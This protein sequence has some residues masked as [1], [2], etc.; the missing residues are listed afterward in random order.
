MVMLA[1]NN[2]FACGLVEK[3]PG[4][5]CNDMEAVD[6]QIEA[7]RAM[8][9]Y[10]DAKQGGPGQGWYR[11]VTSPQ[12]ARDVIYAGKL[13]VVLGIEVDSLFNCKLG[14]NCSIAS[15]RRE[16]KR[17]Y[18]LG[19]RHFFP[20]HLNSNDYG[21][22]AL[23]NVLTT[24]APV[25]LA[26]AAVRDCAT[27]GY[28]FHHPRYVFSPDGKLLNATC[29]AQGLTELGKSLIR[30]MIRAKVFIDVNHMSALAFNDTLTI[31]EDYNYP[32]VAGH[33]GFLD[34]SR[35]DSRH[36]GNLK[37]DQLERIRRLG[38]MVG[39]ILH[40]GEL[41][42]IATY[43]GGPVTVEHLCGNSS[44]TAA[45]AYLYAIA[46]MQGGPVGIGS[47]F[48]GF[49]GLPGPRFGPEACPGGRELVAASTRLQYPFRAAATGLMMD[50][51][52]VGQQTFDL[53]EDGLAHIGM[54]PDL[55]AELENL[56][57]GRADLLDPLLS[58]AEGYIKMWERIETR[59]FDIFVAPTGC[60]ECGDG[61]PENPFGDLDTAIDAAHE[62]DSLFLRPGVY[63]AT[64][65]AFTKNV[66][67]AVWPDTQGGV[68]IR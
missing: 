34:I 15:V 59:R 45:Q 54:L 26:G 10:I 42:E 64:R 11:I 4:R 5:T 39:F 62:G 40:Q 57:A 46:Q 38:G 55:V 66:S 52:V 41:E 6:L 47:D 30:A 7:A 53:N 25:G 14:S 58:S 1:V 24:A 65:K 37:A 9:R 61:S 17:Y 3:A 22:A 20:I 18:N 51:S 29:N 63:Q 68:T 13:A 16:L 19:V 23:Y 49:A 56:F 28:K 60:Q 35:D 21:G 44:E 50:R 36:E 12:Q 33:T 43:R 48:N 67:L 32:V 2:E 31:A 27:E 8:E